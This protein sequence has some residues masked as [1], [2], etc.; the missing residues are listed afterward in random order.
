M[1]E[2]EKVDRDANKVARRVVINIGGVKIIYVIDRNDKMVEEGRR[3]EKQILDDQSLIV[4][5]ADYRQA[6]KVASAILHKRRRKVPT[7]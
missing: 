5:R 1:I 2:I 3:C 4:S 7:S 6:I